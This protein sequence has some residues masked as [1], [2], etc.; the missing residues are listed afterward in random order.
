MLSVSYGRA[1]ELEKLDL[2]FLIPEGRVLDP[3]SVLSQILDSDP[4][5][6]KAWIRIKPDH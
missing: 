3:V 4:A 6:K 1:D 2:F 5:V